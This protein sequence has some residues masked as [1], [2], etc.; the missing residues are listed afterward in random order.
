MFRWSCSAVQVIG[1]AQT[2]AGDASCPGATGK[3]RA[4]TAPNTATL[5]HKTQFIFDSRTRC[6]RTRCERRQSSAMAE[7]ARPS[8]NGCQRPGAFDPKSEIGRVADN[9]ERTESMT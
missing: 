8:R 2:F 4:A 3:T 1:V 9:V 5:Q 6:Y 7:P